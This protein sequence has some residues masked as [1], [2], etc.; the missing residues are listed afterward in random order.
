MFCITIEHKAVA[1]IFLNIL[2]KYYE[3]PI[4]GIL[5]VYFHQK[6]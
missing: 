6:G 5:G 1:T 4:L 2:Q 3:L